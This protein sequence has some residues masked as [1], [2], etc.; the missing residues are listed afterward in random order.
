M[1]KLNKKKNSVI[2]LQKLE[3]RQLL[4]FQDLF[5]I[6]RVKKLMEELSSVQSLGNNK[7]NF[8][9]ENFSNHINK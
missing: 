3:D 7:P 6:Y 5:N 9:N 2:L 1:T 4:L 8:I